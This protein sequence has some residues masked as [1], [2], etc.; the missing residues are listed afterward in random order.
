MGARVDEFEVLD[1]MCSFTIKGCDAA[2][3]KWWSGA[4]TQ[5]LSATEA[6]ARMREAYWKFEGIKARCREMVAD[7]KKALKEAE[8][9]ANM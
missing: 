7:L 1:A 9:E 3:E 6:H 5:G 2:L 8:A 4:Y